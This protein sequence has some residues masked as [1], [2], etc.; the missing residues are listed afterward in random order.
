M[1]LNRGNLGF[2]NVIPHGSTSSVH[3]VGSA[4]TTYV[5]SILIHNLS[6]TAVQNT[7]IHFVPNN[8]GSAGTAG[9]LTQVARIGISTNDTF[10]FEPAYPLTLT[11][12]GDSIQITNEGTAPTSL[13]V[14]VLGD[15]EV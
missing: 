11:S 10:F 1:T 5:K 8:G 6:T 2:T 14:V 9:S 12:T 4:Q 13:N 7:Q 3:T 15:K